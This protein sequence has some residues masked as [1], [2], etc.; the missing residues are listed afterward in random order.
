MSQN[1]FV[2]RHFD[3]KQPTRNEMLADAA[4]SAEPAS[5]RTNCSVYILHYARYESKASIYTQPVFTT[6]ILHCFGLDI[7]FFILLV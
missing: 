7:F 6:L 1:I 3:T 5:N 4:R 2:C